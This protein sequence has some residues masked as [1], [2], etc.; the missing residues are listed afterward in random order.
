[1]ETLHV[2]RGVDRHS[3]RMHRLGR[4]MLS[5]SWLGRL[6]FARECTSKPI[7]QYYDCTYEYYVQTVYPGRMATPG[8]RS[9]AMQWVGVKT[10]I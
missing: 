4:R 3:H 1:M 6:G 5:H 9:W 10:F 2:K 8:G 7:N